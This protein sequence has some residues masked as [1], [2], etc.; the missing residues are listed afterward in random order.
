MCTTFSLR[1]F[2][3]ISPRTES[4]SVLAS[5]V[6]VVLSL[7]TTGVQARKSSFCLRQ[8]DCSRH[9]G[10]GLFGVLA[11][12]AWAQG[13][14][15]P[16]SDPYDIL[17]TDPAAFIQLLDDARPSPV[18]PETKEM[19]LKSL[20]PE[21]E[22]TVL[23]ASARDKLAALYPVLRATRRDAVY[24]V[25]IIDVPQ[26]AVAIHGRAVI[27][28]S[29]PALGVLDADQLRAAVAHEAA[30]E[31]V[32]EE[33]HR[34]ARSN[35]WKR[36]RH[37]ELVC[38][39]IA[40]VILHQLGLD[41]SALITGFEKMIRLN[42]SLGTSLKAWGDPTL[43]Q[44][45]EFARK[46]AAW[47]AAADPSAERGDPTAAAAP[48]A[49]PWPR[50]YIRDVFVRDAARAALIAA[51]TQLELPACQSLLSEFRDQRGQPLTATLVALNTSLPEYARLVVFLDGE[52]QPTCSRHGVLAFTVTGGRVVHVCGRAFARA[53]KKDAL[54]VRAA[55]IH[56]LL[57]S[58]GLGENPPTPAHIT[59]R[60]KRLC[61]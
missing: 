4:W 36:L 33:W 14:S 10:L 31:Y 59:A 2:T 55:L 60:V 51:S 1:T 23:N 22:I 46:V 41:S 9:I 35:D 28:I 15:L 58:L 44:R 53:W 32:W 17:A 43:D 57:H 48:T 11:T 5:A 38:D 52:S 26:A 47:I 29:Q 19:V 25:K 42:L 61:W 7:S 21:G 40:T 54:E 56:E 50:V 18:T 13:Q 16:V 34:A 45:R 39:G 8:H 37:L 20:P 27:L 6:S 30:H 49:E 24:E 12:V 3:S